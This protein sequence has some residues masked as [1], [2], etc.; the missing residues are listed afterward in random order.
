MDIV[1]VIQC[2]YKA[3]QHIHIM[4]RKEWLYV[5]FIVIAVLLV[6]IAI[7][8]YDNKSLSEQL[9]YKEVVS[10]TPIEENEEIKEITT[11]IDSL[12]HE[13]E[14]NR[15]EYE[16]EISIY[17]TNDIDS[18]LDFFEGYVSNYRLGKNS[19]E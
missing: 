11:V 5:Q 10:D 9:Q 18:L 19:G 8:Y 4:V 2:C 7:I 13:R 12:E 6:S 16:K 14:E 1:G 17:V 15:K 3:V